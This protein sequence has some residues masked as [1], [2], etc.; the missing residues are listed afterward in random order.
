MKNIWTWIVLA[1]IVIGGIWW[2]QSTKSPAMSDDGTPAAV[3]ATDD[4]NAQPAGST[5]ASVNAGV[6]ADVNA[7]QTS[8][9]I[10]YNGSSFSP[11]SV[12]VKQ[13]G[14][15][16][17]TSATGNMWVASAPHPTHTGYDGTSRGEHCAAGYTGAAP[18]D[19][20][21]AGPSYTF[22]FNK[23]G[24]WLFHDHMNAGA[25]GSVTVVQ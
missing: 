10:T 4:A 25:H 3:D 20:C 23:V 16:T 7:A 13:G 21:K 5:G 6:T 15:V 22:T 9:T 8:A 11:A 2:W 24:T 12:T 14:S 1:V 17:F 19:Q 18:F